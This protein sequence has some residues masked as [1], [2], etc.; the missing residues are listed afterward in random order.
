MKE[1]IRP[2]LGKLT[3]KYLSGAYKVYE[4]LYWHM[5]NRKKNR[6]L[7]EK[8]YEYLSKIDEILT[9]NGI[10]YF[11]TYGSLLG[12]IREGKFMDYDNDIDFG[13]IKT[14]KFSWENLEKSMQEI[15]MVK[16]HQF[17]LNDKIT[18]QTYVATALSVDFF[19]YEEENG[20]SISYIY[21]HKKDEEYQEN[22]FSVAVNSTSLISDVKRIPF[23]TGTVAVP[24]NP[25]LF[26]REIYGEDWRT[27]IIGWEK[28]RDIVLKEYGYLEK[29][30]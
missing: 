6:G 12:V 28:E 16:K 4:K 30:P 7:H 24:S 14:E 10:K 23:Q 21:Y 13:I 3:R 5:V 26:L 9:R 18:E 27:P 17:L 20:K 1:K 22:Q 29:Q 11:V 8:G 15:G 25:E 2:F 19:L